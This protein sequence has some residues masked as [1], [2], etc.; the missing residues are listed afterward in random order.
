MDFIERFKEA[1]TFSEKEDNIDKTLQILEH[2]MESD[3][4][5]WE[6]QETENDWIFDKINDAI[7][8]IR[9]Y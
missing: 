2:L 5:T 6:N 3:K 4:R 9:G 7:K 1:G 8:L